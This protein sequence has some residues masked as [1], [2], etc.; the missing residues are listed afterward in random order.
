M[1]D[2]RKP[3]SKFWKG[4]NL[5]TQICVSTFAKSC[6]SHVAD[7]CCQFV[8]IIMIAFAQTPMLLHTLSSIT[9]LF[10]LNLT[11]SCEWVV[12]YANALPYLVEATVVDFGGLVG[13][14]TVS[15][16]IVQ[17]LKI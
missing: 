10:A 8:F 6:S 12:A 11:G 15:K 4:Q 1:N 13:G 5:G 3:L 9:H 2:N 16:Y 7:H 14:V 17:Q